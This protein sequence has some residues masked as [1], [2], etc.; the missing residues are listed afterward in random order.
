VLSRL[1]AVLSREAQGIWDTAK[2]LA[3]DLR[4]AAFVVA[5]T[6]LETAFRKNT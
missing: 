2:E 3:T 1:N 6:R 4:R 5:L